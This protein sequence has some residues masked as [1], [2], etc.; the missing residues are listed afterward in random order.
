MRSFLLLSL[1]IVALT[2]CKREQTATATTGATQTIAPASAPSSP[3][4]S[5]AMTQT[6]D[7]EDS[8]SEAEGGTLTNNGGTPPA[9]DTAATAATTS[10]PPAPRKAPAKKKP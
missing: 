7:V 4:G 6:V 3:N 9:A 10:V 5:D 1:L 2:G 8:R